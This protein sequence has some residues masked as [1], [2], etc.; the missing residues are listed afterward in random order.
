MPLFDWRSRANGAI[1][2]RSQS[3]YPRLRFFS[4]QERSSAVTKM[5][6]GY[7]GYAK[8]TKPFSTKFG[9][10]VAHGPR[11]FCGN[12]DHVFTLR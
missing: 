4:A 12:P 9:G 1:E 2:Y 6:T 8:T 7:Y 3:R 5:L 11:K 10:K